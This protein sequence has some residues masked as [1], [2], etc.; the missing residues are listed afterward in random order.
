MPSKAAD[1]M[2]IRLDMLFIAFLPFWLHAA[3]TVLDSQSGIVMQP[4]LLGD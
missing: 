1:A 3:T 2:T 4:D